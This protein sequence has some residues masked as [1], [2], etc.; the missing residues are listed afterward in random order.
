MTF[1]VAFSRIRNIALKEDPEAGDLQAGAWRPKYRP[2]P[3]Q[4]RVNFP[5]KEQL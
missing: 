3:H 5:L 2:K 4:L 1:D